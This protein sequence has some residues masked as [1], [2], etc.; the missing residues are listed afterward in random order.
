M[1]NVLAALGITVALSSCSIS[2]PY[3]ERL[4]PE[5]VC[6]GYPAPYCQPNSSKKYS[7]IKSG[8][9]YDGKP[10]NY[11]G[12]S[13][14][15]FFETSPCVGVEV[16]D[17]DVV[18]SGEQS[19]TGMLRNEERTKF[20]NKLSADIV[21]LIQLNGVPVPPGVTADIS[22][23]VERTVKNTDIS[24]IELQYKRI[25][26]SQEFMDSHLESCL[27][28][29]P[30]SRRVSTGI[31]VITV[32]GS[33]T[34]DKVADTLASVEAKASY[35]IMSDSAKAEYQQAK[36]RAMKGQFKPVSFVFAVAHRRGQR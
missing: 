31:S 32:S 30:R 5:Y 6:G 13:F 17:S 4:D 25:D 27:V 15:S 7:R 36:T 10:K 35:N 2:V 34:S 8:A 28:K 19:V 11:L 29:T 22:A 1:K 21:A 23:E 33:W 20:A 3:Y 26:L 24:S 18:I 12:R 9:D 14:V 16:T